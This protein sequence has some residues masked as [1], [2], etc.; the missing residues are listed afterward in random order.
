MELLELARGTQD[1]IELLSG[2]ER[3]TDAFDPATHSGHYQLMASEGV[4]AVLLPRLMERVCATAPNL[5]LTVGVVEPWR[6]TR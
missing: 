5:R 4:T 2:A 3:I 6:P 1:A